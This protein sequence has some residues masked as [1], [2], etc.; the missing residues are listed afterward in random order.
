VLETLRERLERRP[1]DYY[2]AERVDLGVDGAKESKGISYS[3]VRHCRTASTTGNL[4][5]EPASSAC[6][7]N[8]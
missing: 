1:A 2:W 6:L 4:L 7:E 5:T 8:M 3:F